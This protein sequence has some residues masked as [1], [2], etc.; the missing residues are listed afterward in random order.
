MPQRHPSPARRT[1]APLRNG[2]PE[3]T[4]RAGRGASRPRDKPDEVRD[5]PQLTASRRARQAEAEAKAARQELQGLQDAGKS[6][7]EKATTRAERAEARAAELERSGADHAPWPPS[8]TCTPSWSPGSE[9]TPRRSWRPTPRRWP[10]SSPDRQETPPPDLGARTPGTLQRRP[11]PRGS[12]TRSDGARKAAAER[13]K[14]A[15]PLIQTL[16]EGG[17]A[18]PSTT[19]SA[20]PMRTALIPE[21]VVTEIMQAA[22]EQSAALA[23]FP[24][25]PMSTKTR[26]IPA[27]SALPVAYFV[28]GDTGLKQTT[29]MAWGGLYLEAEEIAAIVPVPEAVLDDADYDI[30]A[31]VQPRLAEAVGRTLDQA[32][33]NGHRQARQLADGVDPR[34]HRGREHLRAGHQRRR[35]R[36]RGR[37]HLRAVR[38]GGGRRLHRGRPRGHGHLQ[39]APAQRPGRQRRAA[40]RGQRRH[41][42]RGP[43]PVHQP[44]PVAA[45]GDRRGA[46]R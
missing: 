39:G 37:R 25:V 15:P 38:R 21:D 7:L 5:D 14:G 9:V 24:H 12:P 4:R 36:W 33:F 19:S 6:E 34:R 42:L 27:L 43:D 29:E 16:A 31:Q 30:W 26:R 20:A 45:P 17:T 2:G 8:T 40:L 35:R 22:V 28:N 3:L 41:D 1:R 23:L 13:R 18:C 44:D 46:G 10:S 32:I 11:A